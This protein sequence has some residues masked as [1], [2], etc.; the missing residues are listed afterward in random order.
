MYGR[1][2]LHAFGVIWGQALMDLKKYPKTQTQ[3]MIQNILSSCSSSKEVFVVE[4][5]KLYKLCVLG[6]PEAQEL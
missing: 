6:T 5:T 2:A 4:E 1:R 3:T